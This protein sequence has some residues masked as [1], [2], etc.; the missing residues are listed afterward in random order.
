MKTTEKIYGATD[1]EYRSR[2][3]RSTYRCDW[4]FNYDA[5]GMSNLYEEMERKLL[6]CYPSGKQESIAEGGFGGYGIKLSLEEGKIDLTWSEDGNY[7]NGNYYPGQVTLNL[8][9]RSS[10]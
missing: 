7:V 9:V 3:F 1:C 10:R 4:D 5:S 2:R 6:A 8:S